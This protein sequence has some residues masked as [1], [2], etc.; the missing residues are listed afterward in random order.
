MDYYIIPAELAQKLSLTGFRAGDSEHGYIVNTSDLVTISVAK[1]KIWG[2][3]QITAWEA[4]KII[5]EIN[6]K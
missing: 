6:N 5:N 2:A 3:R 1:A 4:R